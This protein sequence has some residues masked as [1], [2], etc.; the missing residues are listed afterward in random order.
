[1]EFDVSLET[2]KI[3]I[4]FD[5]LTSISD[6]NDPADTEAALDKLPFDPLLLADP[7]SVV[8]KTLPADTVPAK[9]D[10]DPW[11][12]E[13]L[14]SIVPDDDTIFTCISE[15]ETAPAMV[16]SSRLETAI[17]DPDTAPAIVD[18]DPWATES[19]TCISDPD[20]APATVDRDPWATESLTCISDPDTAPATV[21]NSRLET[22]I[23]DPETA[24]A[25]VESDP[26]AVESE[27]A[28]DV[29]VMLTNCSKS[30]LTLNDDDDILL[31]MFIILCENIILFF[32][33][34]IYYI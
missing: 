20:T 1:M 14:T 2:P 28:N 8:T 33:I 30:E 6:E 21:D 22:A 11:A 25:I 18:S 5:A 4:F 29:L 13:S 7:A 17:C 12:V 26:C 9:V 27:T 31:D 3:V 15:P 23:C 24:P 19:L 34:V 16:D 10:R 32:F